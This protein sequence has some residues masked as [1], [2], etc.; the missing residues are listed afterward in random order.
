MPQN[1]AQV[2]TE[3]H[4]PEQ[5]LESFRGFLSGVGIDLAGSLS[6]DVRLTST[7]G[8]LR[9]IASGG[10]ASQADISVSGTLALSADYVRFLAM[11]TALKD[12]NLQARIAENRLELGPKRPEQ[13]AARVVIRATGEDGA[14]SA[15]GDI[16]VSGSLPLV[17]NGA[18]APGLHIEARSIQF[19][20]APLP[21]FATG[22][23]RGELGSEDDGAGLK[24][25]VTGSL[26]EPTVSGTVSVRNTALRLPV[27][28]PITARALSVG[29]ID[30]RFDISVALGKNVTVTNSLM[31][32]SLTTSGGQP[33]K[34]TGLLSAPKLAGSLVIESG[35]LTFP[36]ARFTIAR[37]GRVDVRY[38][39]VTAS[40]DGKAGL[41]VAVN[42]TATSYVTAT[43]VTGVRRRYRVTVEAR[44]PLLERPSESEDPTA[45]RL[46]LTYRTEPPDLALSQAGVAQ[47]VTAL[48]GGQ[49]AIQAVFSRQGNVG[50]VLMGQAVDY[51]GGALLPDVFGEL[52]LG[53]TLGLQ[54]FSVDYSS[55][56]AFVL[57]MSRELFGPFDIAYWRRVA[58]GKETVGDAG[59]WELRLGLRLRNAFRLTYSVDS[60]RTNAYLLEGV[61]SF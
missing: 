3:L 57:R 30:P 11:R 61:Y 24:F 48:L 27:T 41:E 10:T 16:R 12:V 19:D 42:L 13:P 56:G 50:G 45:G 31:A 47:R 2:E 44:G 46:K 38:P 49:E 59:A 58:G 29:I 34:L 43:S 14:E 7:V 32:A 25:A 1:D 37:G 35:K 5:H 39:G 60:Q 4:V 21:G 20:E 36:T 22:R 51:L 26:L 23:V 8:V 55:T 28:D 40:E 53:R 15:A 52:G 9:R 17:G 18:E 33:I 54:E 6:G